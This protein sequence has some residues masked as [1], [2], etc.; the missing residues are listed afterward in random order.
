MMSL[1]RE[2]KNQRGLS[3]IEAVM[4]IGMSA[5]ILV[6]ISKQIIT[7]N[8]I[9]QS[10]SGRAQSLGFIVNLRKNIRTNYLYRTQ[11]DIEL[12]AGKYD[13]VQYDPDLSPPQ[14]TL[15]TRNE[16][17]LNKFTATRYETKCVTNLPA[18]GV[19]NLPSD[20]CNDRHDPCEGRFNIQ[21]TFY[22]D[23]M[24]AAVNKVTHYPNLSRGQTTLASALC[25]F[26]A[27]NEKVRMKFAYATRKP[28]STDIVWKIEDFELWEDTGRNT[29]EF[30]KGR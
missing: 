25:V 22:A 21:S 24:V 11:I 23:E 16:S 9:S 5:I 10:I 12:G 6:V 26:A 8:A 7:N 29:I 14:F 2:T 13:G 18:L 28:L 30:L 4:A 27:D 20:F 3:L 19:P 1:S 17:D 15:R